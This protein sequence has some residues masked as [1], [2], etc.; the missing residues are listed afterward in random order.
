MDD[1]RL[2]QDV[3][4]QR[5]LPLVRAVGIVSQ[6]G[7][8]QSRDLRGELA[9]LQDGE[10]ETLRDS[11]PA[12]EAVL[13]RPLNVALRENGRPARLRTWDRQVEEATRQ[14][15]VDLAADV[16]RRGQAVHV[17][18]VGP[19]DHMIR[20]RPTAMKIVCG[21]VEDLDEGPALRSIGRGW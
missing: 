15:R 12:R 8:R 16:H 10:T 19:E 2:R 5:R 20:D 18:E 3:E 17:Q 11:L 21:G 6:A 4:P 1:L 7:R 14:Q 9:V 13:A